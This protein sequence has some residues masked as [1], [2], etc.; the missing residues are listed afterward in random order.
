MREVVV[1][2]DRIVHCFNS[3]GRLSCT[4]SCAGLVTGATRYQ[5]LS[6]AEAAVPD[7]KKCPRCHWA[8]RPPDG[9]GEDDC[10]GHSRCEDCGAVLV[11]GSGRRCPAC[12]AA[13]TP[14]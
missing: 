2:L 8:E 12:G 6:Q 9:D 10:F 11:A 7:L 14:D 13:N 4:D 1:G 3:S 5:N